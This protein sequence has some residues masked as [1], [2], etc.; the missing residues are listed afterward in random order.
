VTQ[1][2][3]YGLATLIVLSAMLIGPLGCSQGPPRWETVC[4]E[5]GK[6]ISMRP[7]LYECRRA[8]K[9]CIDPGTGGKMEDSE[10]RP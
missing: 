1:K 2:A 7:P 3:F 9:V 10:C 6:M 8:A 5:Q 4:I